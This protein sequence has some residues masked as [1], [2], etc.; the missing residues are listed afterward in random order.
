MRLA[1]LIN[2]VFFMIG[3]G[4]FGYSMYEA[5]KAYGS[6]DWP[7]VKGTIV[8]S[9][10]GIHSGS[11]DGTTYTPDVMYE[12]WVQGKLYRA[13]NI[14]PSK[15]DESSPADAQRKLDRFPTGASV[16]VYYNPADP[17]DALLEPGMELHNYLIPFVGIFVMADSVAFPF[18]LQ[19]VLNRRK[20]RYDTTE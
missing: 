4:I 7:T 10:I 11:E 14:R 12:Y 17:Y 15:L 8:D 5:V 2:A 3:L 18:I 13:G 1:I 9:R 20:S 6:T 19:V 16:T